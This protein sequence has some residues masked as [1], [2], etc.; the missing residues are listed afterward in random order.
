[1]YA[2]SLVEAVATKE[3]YGWQCLG[4]FVKS[5]GQ[6][7][8]VLVKLIIWNLANIKGQSSGHL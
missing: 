5:L 7:S 8:N 2:V 4:E 3:A 1:M 6:L